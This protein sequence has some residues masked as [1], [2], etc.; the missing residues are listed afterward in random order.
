MEH[1]VFRAF[2][3]KILD[4]DQGIVESIVAVMGNL[5]EGDDIIHP[6]AF[7]KTLSERGLKIRVLDSHNTDSILRVIGKPLSI[8]ELEKVELPQSLLN[9]YPEATGALWAKTQFLLD[10]PEGKGAFERIKQ[11][12]VGDWSIGYDTMDSDNSIAQ[13]D[14]KEVTARNLR[15][16]KLYEYSPTI[17]GMNQAATT[18]SAKSAE[19]TE[20]K[21]Y[22]AIR[23]DGK[24]RVYKLDADG[25]PTGKPLGEHD[26]E[27]EAIAQ[28]EALYANT[29]EGKPTPGKADEPVTEAKAGRVLARRNADRIKRAY[30]ALKEALDDAGILA[31]LADDDE[32]ETEETTGPQKNVPAPILPETG[33][34]EGKNA[35]VDYLTLIKIERLKAD[36]WR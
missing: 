3:T 8:R 4:T 34:Q 12:A 10:T 31:M 1:K 27:D 30:D 20:G 36:V 26:T 5:D 6:S 29:D 19:P 16:L 2:E 22:R 25:K 13:R 28:V 21:P 33:P 35:P 15:T 7:R 14:G 24:W 11:G 17:F 23:E 32:E 9:E 18:L